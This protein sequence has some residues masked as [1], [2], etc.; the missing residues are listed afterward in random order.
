MRSG[1]GP[2]Q[3]GFVTRGSTGAALPA[4]VRRRVDGMR[5]LRMAAVL[6]GVAALAVYV[7]PGLPAPAAHWPLWDVRVY[8]WGGRQAAAGGA[9][10][11]RSRRGVQLHLSPVRRV[12]VLGRRGCPGRRDED[13]HDRGKRGRAGGAVRA[14]AGRGR[15]PAA[16]GDRLRGLGAGPADPAGR[17]H[18]AP[19]RGQPDPGRADRRGPAPSPG[20]GLV[21]GHRH[22]AGRR[23]QAHPADLRGLPGLDRPAA[24][25]GGR[26]RDLRG[27][28]RGGIRLAA[29]ERPGRSG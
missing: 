20:R 21:A 22:R 13:R 25:G 18:A 28:R 29:R 9:G 15:G 26:G 23:D 3:I 8:W 19:G 16:P 7:L 1:A 17:L 27:H 4:W 2:R 6:A 10:A 11:V 12:A 14:G 5:G 24:G